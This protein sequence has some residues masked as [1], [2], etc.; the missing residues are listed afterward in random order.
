[1][2]AWVLK[3]SSH[4]KL[5]IEDVQPRDGSSVGW[6]V[7]LAWDAVCRWGVQTATSGHLLALPCVGSFRNG[8][9]TDAGRVMERGRAV[10]LVVQWCRGWH[11]KVFPP[12]ATSEFI[13]ALG[14]HL[15]QMHQQ[16]QM[17]SIHTALLS[18]GSTVTC[19]SKEACP[20][21]SAPPF[22]VCLIGTWI[23]TKKK[24]LA[25][26]WRQAMKLTTWWLQHHNEGSGSYYRIWKMCKGL[27]GKPFSMEL[28]PLHFHNPSSFT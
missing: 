9:I 3:C 26:S 12:Q 5:C 22:Q 27:E 11:H 14:Q 20:T 6:Q 16:I 28:L 4:W 19:A 13:T 18:M 8:A 21:H 1:M 17:S 10:A 2:F 15:R 24:R 7:V 25:M 23:G